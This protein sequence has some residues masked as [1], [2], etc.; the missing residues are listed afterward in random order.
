L[1]QLCGN[2]ECLEYK[3]AESVSFVGSV[4]LFIFRLRDSR[5]QYCS[6][7]CANRTHNLNRR[8]PITKPKPV[9]IQA[10]KELERVIGEGYEG[11][12]EH[13]ICYVYK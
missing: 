2:A 4:L 3:Y 1:S 5:K 10:R 11:Y 12:N 8:P 13:V 9:C 7:Y 6:M